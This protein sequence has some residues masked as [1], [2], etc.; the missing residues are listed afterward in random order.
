MGIVSIISALPG[1][2][3]DNLVALQ[4]LCHT[5]AQLRPE[6]PVWMQGKRSLT[7]SQKNS[8]DFSLFVSQIR[9]VTGASVHYNGEKPRK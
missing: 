5:A 4:Q 8:G 1:V 3:N 2:D 6:K 7:F 9:L